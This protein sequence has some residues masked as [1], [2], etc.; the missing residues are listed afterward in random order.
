MDCRL[1]QRDHSLALKCGIKLMLASHEW[2]GEQRAIFQHVSQGMAVETS[3]CRYLVNVVDLRRSPFDFQSIYS[4]HEGCHIGFDNN[5]SMEWMP[6][7]DVEVVDDLSL[8]P[9]HCMVFFIISSKN[10][11]ASSV[12]LMKSSS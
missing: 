5:F 7:F 2:I 9:S 11:H 4:F 3:R 1:G 8:K 10:F 6:P 12:I